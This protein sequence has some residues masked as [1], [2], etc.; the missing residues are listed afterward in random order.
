MTHVHRTTHFPIK[1]PAGHDFFPPG[2]VPLVAQQ[3]RRR[4]LMGLKPGADAP[5]ASLRHPMNLCVH[6]LH[7]SYKMNL[8]GRADELQAY[9]LINY[10]TIKYTHII[11]IYIYIIYIDAAPCPIEPSTVQFPIQLTFQIARNWK[12]VRREEAST[13]VQKGHIMEY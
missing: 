5:V 7:C 11:H 4:L 13:R 1:V 2:T 6:G 12:R 3:S 9:I 8:L 10:V